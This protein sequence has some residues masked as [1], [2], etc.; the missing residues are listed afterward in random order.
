MALWRQHYL[1]SLPLEISGKVNVEVSQRSKL[2]TES[3]V[4][5]MA[6][7][8]TQ[9]KDV[10]VPNKLFDYDINFL[11]NMSLRLVL[12]YPYSASFVFASFFNL[13]L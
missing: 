1:F 5:K 6:M 9:E 4:T 10:Q 8:F 11:E 13:S 12:T 3:L 2:W 7:T